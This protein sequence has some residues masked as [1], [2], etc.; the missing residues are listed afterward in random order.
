MEYAADKISPNLLAENR[1]LHLL[2]N[3]SVDGSG[4]DIN[5]LWL[6]IPRSRLPP[7]LT[8]S[9]TCILLGQIAFRT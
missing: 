4:S 9:P 5:L 8:N 2:V 3:R 6:A 7:P 1:C